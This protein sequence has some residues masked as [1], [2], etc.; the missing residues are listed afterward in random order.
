MIEL[1]I[2]CLIDL[3][4]GDG[5]ETV[6]GS[7]RTKN[8]SRGAKIAVVVTA[9]LLV[10]AVTAVLVICGVSYLMSGERETGAILLVAGI[11]FLIT[12]IVRFRIVYVSIRKK[13]R[14]DILLHI[15]KQNLF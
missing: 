7:D 14:I 4:I 5:A 9:I 15:G 10:I 3:I 11:G 12:T 13:R 2:E 8:W 1:I 6:S